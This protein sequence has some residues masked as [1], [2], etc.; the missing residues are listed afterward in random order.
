MYFIRHYDSASLKRLPNNT[1]ALAYETRSGRQVAFYVSPR[2]DPDQL[3]EQLWM[4]FGGNG[5]LALDWQDIAQG[6]PD[7]RTGFLLIDY[8]GFGACQGAPNRTSILQSSEQALARLADHLGVRM[9]RFAGRI[10]LMGHSLGSATALQFAPDHRVERIVLLA[11]FTNMI[12][13]AEYMVGWPLCHL[14]PERFDNRARLAELAFHNPRP[15]VAIIHGAR[16]SIVPVGMGR[17]LA[18]LYP[19]WIE[20]HEISHADHQSFFQEDKAL[21][22]RVMRGTADPMRQA[23]R[24]EGAPRAY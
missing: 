12:D 17:S 11:P 6:Y 8:P 15:K 3:P 21:I 1:K 4:V 13:I 9:D 2:Q 23:T 5:A 7:L 20:Y 24:A 22:Y 10:N 19:Q 18:A 14:V 16:D